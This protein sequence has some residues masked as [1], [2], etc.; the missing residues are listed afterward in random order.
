MTIRARILPSLHLGV[1]LAA[2]RLVAVLP[3]SESGDPWRRALSPSP[4]PSVASPDLATAFA[5]LRE[6]LREAS[7]GRT[8]RAVLH[9]ALLPPLVHWRRIRLPGLRIDEVRQVLR[10]EPS[11]YLPIAADPA[12]LVIELEGTGWRERSPFTMVAAPRT[13][14]EGICAAAQES[15][16]EIAELVPAHAAWAASARSSRHVG[17]STERTLLIAHHD[18]IDVV[19]SRGGCA[20]EVRRLPAALRA[21]VPDSPAAVQAPDALAARFAPRAG[22]PALLPES[23][24]ALGAR[25]TR[26]AAITRLAAAAALVFA[27]GMIELWG[28]TRERAMIA[29]ERARLRASVAEALATREAAAQATTRLAAVRSASESAPR[30]SALIASLAES[31][32]DDAFLVALGASGDSLRLEGIAPRAAPV[33]DAVARIEGVRS[34]H[35]DGPIRQERSITGATN[36]RFTL[37]ASMGG[38]P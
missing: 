27:A 2:D 5:E 30:W 26:I 24:R 32:P 17:R 4:D 13:L 36:E 6:A 20:T 29:G 38:R 3:G 9:V 1:A 33:F 35:P 23:V 18:R 31:L 37:T 7:H 8:R 21:T 14:I 10:R 19:T 25:R 12:P 22:G 16:W 11:R 28:S 34:L 15:G